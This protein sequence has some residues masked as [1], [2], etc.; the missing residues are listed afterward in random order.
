MA[1]ADFYDLRKF[2][3]MDQVHNIARYK[4]DIIGI[5]WLFLKTQTRAL[6]P[7]IWSYNLYFIL[8]FRM[9]IVITGKVQRLQ[10]L[11]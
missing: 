6:V 7:T 3:I 4:M 11:I 8:D 9:L 2:Y 5:L 10:I 1:E